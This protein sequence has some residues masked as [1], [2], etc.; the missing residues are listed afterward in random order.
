MA[1]THPRGLL[2]EDEAYDQLERIS[3][4]A[5]SKATLPREVDLTPYCPRVKNQ[6]DLA[7]CV[8]WSTGYAAMTIDKAIS[9]NWTEEALI[10][11]NAYS[12]MFVFNHTKAGEDC[13]KGARI[14]DA[15][16]FL[17]KKGNLPA[18]EFDFNVD[19]CDKKAEAYHFEQAAAHTISDFATLFDRDA[20]DFV[21]VQQVKRALAG[22]L[23][24]SGKPKPVIIGMDIRNNFIKLRNAKFWWPDNGNTT[25]AGGHAMVVVGYDD[26]VS[27]FRLFNSWGKSWGNLGTIQVKYKDF[28]KFCKY[29]YILYSK[30]D[31]FYEK[32]APLLAQVEASSDNSTSTLARPNPTNSTISSSDN[33]NQKPR[34]NPGITVFDKPNSRS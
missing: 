5:S 22:E 2:N 23:T 4:H 14:V 10:S 3:V 20:N 28:A 13:I 32:P 7:S 15:I 25:P 8:G 27:A 12:A 17:M 30:E 6:G 16:D 34:R 29:G 18:A 21:K 33:S 26:Q 31:E 19:N 9:E 1:Q 11:E 24:P